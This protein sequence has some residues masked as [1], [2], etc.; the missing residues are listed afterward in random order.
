MNVS[1][2]H[3][4]QICEKADLCLN[5]YPCVIK[6]Y[7]ILS[8]VLYQYCLRLQ[9]IKAGNFKK[10]LWKWSY[11]GGKKPARKNRSVGKYDDK[12]KS[13]ILTYGALTVNY[14]YIDPR[15]TVR[16]E[17]N[18]LTIDCKGGEVKANDYY[19]DAVCGKT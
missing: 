2:C 8:P 17:G 16:S 4:G 15:S 18:Q 6:Y 1:V 9:F 5:L 11:T 14:T 3:Q 13:A 12:S 7:L 19:P 10:R